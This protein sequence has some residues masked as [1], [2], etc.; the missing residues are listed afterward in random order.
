MDS[1]PTGVARCFCVAYSENR[2]SAQAAALRARAIFEALGATVYSLE[3][4][5]EGVEVEALL[6]I[7]G[8]GTLLHSA[9]LMAPRGIP[10]LGVN[11]GH[12]GYLCAARED[13][14][15]Q[16]I[17]S[18]Y[19]KTYNIES[20]SMLRAR[21]FN[22]HEEVWQVD[23]LNEMLVGGSNRTLTLELLVNGENV[24]LIRGDG[25]IVSTRTGSTA[26]AFSAG[27][28]VLLMEALVL[29]AS[30]PVASSIVTP[31]V[32][33]TDTVFRIRNR[34]QLARP[35]VIADGQKDYQIDEGTEIEMTLSPLHAYFAEPGL[36]SAV[37][38]LKK[39]VIQR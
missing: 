24:G 37:G 36:I 22:R 31:V 15:E 6:S 39:S 20:R 14:L 21:V 9:R 27:G 25:I 32:C 30:N 17:E 23:S 18:L 34:T 29:V 2:E 38:K 7:G 10:V 5:L 11:F 28:P 35:Y 12:V 26:Y 8:D 19:A 3:Q 4:V 16:A 1:Q 33:S 13:Q